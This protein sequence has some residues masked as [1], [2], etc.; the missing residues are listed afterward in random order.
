MC[1][2]FNISY[3]FP[4]ILPID[5]VLETSILPKGTEVESHRHQLLST[6]KVESER[7]LVEHLDTELGTEVEVADEEEE[8]SPSSDEGHSRTAILDH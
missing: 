6:T 3:C 2:H 8:E 5:I 1:E 7:H 4:C